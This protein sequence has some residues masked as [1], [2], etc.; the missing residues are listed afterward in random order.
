M[1]HSGLHDMSTVLITMPAVQYV[2]RHEQSKSHTDVAVFLLFD[3][4]AFG[5]T[6]LLHVGRVCI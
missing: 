3:A 4:T 6:A 2:S 1:A 5:S